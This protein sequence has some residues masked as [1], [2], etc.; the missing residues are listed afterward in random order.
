MAFQAVPDVAEVVIQYV[1]NGT[2]QHNVLHALKAGGYDA[3][4][5]LALAVAADASVVADWLP[6]QTADHSYV[7]T[8]VR[9]LAFL[10]DQETTVTAGAAVGGVATAGL[11]GNVT[12]AVQKQ[13]GF[14]GRNARGR[15]YWVGLPEVQLRSDENKLI[16]TD[17]VAIVDAIDAMRLALGATVWTPVIVSRFLDGV[18]RAVGVTFTWTQ[19]A[20]TDDNVDSMRPRLL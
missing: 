17:A 13:S 6:I 16:A 1:G 11:P 20:K 18:K 19:T 3:A 4:D 14:T 15:V 12:F 10:N 2:T 7:S 8:T 9:G 5:L